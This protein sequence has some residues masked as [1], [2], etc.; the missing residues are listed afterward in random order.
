MKLPSAERAVV[1]PEK[2]RDYL[3]SPTHPVGRFKA[4]YFGMLGFHLENWTA[5]QD[6]LR[7]IPLNFPASQG[8]FSRFGNKY[9]VPAMLTGPNGRTAS[10]VTVWIVPHGDDVPRLVTATPGDHP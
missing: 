2:V 1:E 3:L 10:V 9:E 8:K 7:Q 5:L 4:A 6:A